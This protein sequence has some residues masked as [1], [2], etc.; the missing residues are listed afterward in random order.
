MGRLTIGSDRLLRALAAAVQVVVQ[1]GLAFALAPR[2]AALGLLVAALSA[3]ALAPAL[4]RARRAGEDTTRGG[5]KRANAFSDFLASIKLAKAHDVQD[6]HADAFLDAGL[7]LH[8]DA[9]RFADAQIRSA[10]VFQFVAALTACCIVTVGLFVVGTT[11]ATLSAIL[12]LA[13]RVTGPVQQ[14]VGGAQG[15]ATVIPA[16][17][18]LIAL[19]RSLAAAPVPVACATPMR[20]APATGPAALAFEDVRF[21]YP[22][23]DHDVLNGVSATIAPGEFVALIGASGAGK[24]T[25]ADI[26]TGLLEPDA[27]AFRVDGAIVR[28]GAALGRWRRDLGYLP[29]EPFLF[30]SSLRRNLTWSAPEAD[31]AAIWQALDQA[32]SRAFVEALPDGLDTRLGER[33]TRLSGGERQRICL[34]RAL[35]RAPRLLLLDEA[36]SALDAETERR[37]LQTLRELDGSVTVLMITHRLP[38]AINLDRVLRLTAGRIV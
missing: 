24:S 28:G 11:P 36:T 2:L 8:A 14:L 3:P 30:D 13:L 20:A 26:V 27:G 12:V 5:R 10:M 32:Q 17:A 31:T 4:R 16:A 15:I 35:L 19:E 6:G 18:A 7:R 21:R 9:I 22:G 1:V 38:P 34:A 23:V 37:L 33:G 29:Q 25:L